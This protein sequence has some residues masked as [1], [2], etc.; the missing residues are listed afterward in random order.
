MNT[1]DDKSQKPKSDQDD[2][3]FAPGGPRSRKSVH[4]AQGPDASQSG[5]DFVIAPGGPRHRKSVRR[6]NSG[7]GFLFDA[8]AARSR[9]RGSASP[10][11][12]DEANWITWGYWADAAQNAVTYLASTWI[13]P[14]EPTAKASQLIYLFNGLEPASGPPLILQ[15]VLQWGDS[16]IGQ[17]GQGPFWSIASWLVGGPDDSA[18]HTP[19]IRVSP[20]DSLT[21]VMKLVSRSAAGCTY[22][23]EF[24]NRAGT[25]LMTPPIPDLIWCYE[26]LEAYELQG[27]HTP[28]YDLDDP[29]EWPPAPSVAFD[30][31]DIMTNTASPNGNWGFT[32]LVTNYG[33]HTTIVRATSTNGETDLYFHGA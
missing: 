33:E 5:S 19:H 8:T 10:G 28:P 29:T 3:V 21:G 4:V 20:G 25:T 9:L 11:P 2:F 16:G 30:A 12:P 22:S 23:C 6:V 24:L 7:Q 18:T 1:P 32:D 26:T 27:T 13:V 17:D 14:P 31:I 15:P